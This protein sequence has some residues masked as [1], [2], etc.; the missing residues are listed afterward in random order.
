MVREAVG[1]IG[2]RDVDLNDDEVGMVIEIDRLDVLV[3][4]GCLDVGVEIRRERGEAERREQGVLDRPPV[5]AGGFSQGRQDELG[6]AHARKYNLNNFTLQSTSNRRRAI[7]TASPSKIPGRRTGWQDG[8][9]IRRP[10]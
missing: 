1:A 10:A 4:D 2:V 5:R 7:S 6:A 8:L 3:L 9:S